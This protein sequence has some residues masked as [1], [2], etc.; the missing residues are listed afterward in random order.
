MNSDK[1]GERQYYIVHFK[2]ICDVID[3][4]QGIIKCCYCNHEEKLER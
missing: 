2:D 1:Y 4:E 3:K